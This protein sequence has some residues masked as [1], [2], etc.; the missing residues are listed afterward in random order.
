MS[1]SLPHYEDSMESFV[2]TMEDTMTASETKWVKQAIAGGRQAAPSEEAL[3]RL[4]DLWTYKEA[5]T[6]NIGLG[7]GFDF[8]RIEV[9]FWNCEG[10]DR[11]SRR[12]AAETPVLKLSERD[13]AKVPAPERQD[14]HY[15]FTEID[16]PE[17]LHNAMHSSTAG[18]HSAN[19]GSSKLVT[20]SGPFPPTP[21]GRLLP[22]VSPP[23]SLARAQEAG[24]LTLWQMDGLVAHAV[25]LAASAAWR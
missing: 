6:K 13:E 11:D 25:D 22:Q 1:V 17:S 15:V 24:V 20:C 8:K 18:S 21:S 23:L 10:S 5:L 19:P 14:P 12:I 4:Y 3:Q 2:E 16:L 9:Q 7:L